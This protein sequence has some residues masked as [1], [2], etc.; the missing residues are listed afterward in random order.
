LGWSARAHVRAGET[1][2]PEPD[3]Y[4]YRVGTVVKSAIPPKFPTCPN[5][6]VDE[7]RLEGPCI[8]V[9]TGNPYSIKS[10]TPS[11][12]DIIGSR[13]AVYIYLLSFPF[14]QGLL[15]TMEGIWLLS[16]LHFADRKD[17]LAYCHHF[18]WV[19]APHSTGSS[20]VSGT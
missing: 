6:L 19:D 14:L 1:S 17:H 5:N 15:Q 10:L 16:L 20:R 18:T 4:S 11:R 3:I 2:Y 8:R 9:T 12:H 13:N 7:L